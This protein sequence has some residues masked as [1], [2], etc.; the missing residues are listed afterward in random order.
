MVR[1]YKKAFEKGKIINQGTVQVLQPPPEEA[2]QPEITEY[3]LVKF[4]RTPSE[5]QDQ[6]WETVLKNAFNLSYP[7]KD[8]DYKEYDPLRPLSVS[9]DYLRREGAKLLRMKSKDGKTGIEFEHYKLDR[10]SISEEKWRELISGWADEKEK[11][12]WLFTVSVMGITTEEGVELAEGLFREAV[13]KNCPEFMGWAKENRPELLQRWEN[14]TLG[15]ECGGNE[16]R[17]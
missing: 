8:G 3:Q 4:R 13:K 14:G 7:G 17:F 2:I 12:I 6:I 9:L 10:G 15:L 5:T 16:N 1:D 11:L